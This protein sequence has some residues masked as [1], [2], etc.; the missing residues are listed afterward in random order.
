L[1]RFAAV[2]ALGDEGN[3]SG[4]ING[5][6]FTIVSILGR[7]EAVNA[8]TGDVWGVSRGAGI[9]CFARLGDDLRFF[10]HFV[11]V[12]K[13]GVEILVAVEIQFHK[14]VPG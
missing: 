3:G 12:L 14:T 10:H 13:R 9:P 11:V 7:S 6:P 1:K 4:A 8:G 2:D 5:R